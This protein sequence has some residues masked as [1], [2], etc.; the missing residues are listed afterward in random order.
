MFE[1][2]AEEYIVRKFGKLTEIQRISIPII[3]QRKNCLIM[4]PTGSGKTLG[5]LVPA[6][7]SS[8]S[9]NSGIKVIY[10]T[11]LKAL[12]RDIGLRM[13]LFQELGVRYGIRHG[14]SSREERKKQVRELPDVIITTP[15]TFQ[16]MLIRKDFMLK[17]ID[18]VIIDELHELLESKRGVQLSL[19]LERLEKCHGANFCRVGL[20]ATISEPE[21]A[22][23]FLCGRNREGFI[24]SLE[25]EREYEI[26]VK[27]PMPIKDIANE[28]VKESETEKVLVFT[29]TRESAEVFANLMKNKCEVHHGSLSKNVREHAEK[30]FREGKTKILIATSSLE[31]GIDIGDI[32]RVI[33]IGSPK[34]VEKLL[35]RIGRSNHHCGSRAVGTIYSLSREDY[36]EALA[37]VEGMKK[38]YMQSLLKNSYDVIAQQALGIVIEMGECDVWFV[39][40]VLSGST[41]YEIEIK[42]LAQILFEMSRNNLLIYEPR[43]GK[44]FARR[45]GVIHYLSTLSFI[46]STEKFTMMDAITNKKIAYLDS[47]F[48]AKLEQEDVFIVKGHAWKAV[49]I[50]DEKKIVRAIPEQSAIAIPEWLGEEIP[51][52]E[53][54]AKRVAEMLNEK[55]F[56]IE[57]IKH[58]DVFVIYTHLGLKKNKALELLLRH[59]FSQEKYSTTT[60]SDGYRIVIRDQSGFLRKEKI[61]E[62]IKNLK[63]DRYEDAVQGS[64]HYMNTLLEVLKHFGAVEPSTGYITRDYAKLWKDT[65]YAEEALCYCAEKYFDKNCI[66]DITKETLFQERE[67]SERSKEFFRTYGIID[68]EGG[69][70]LENLRDNIL[71]KSVEL[72]CCYCHA[73]IT[74][75]V[76]SV[77]ERPRCHRCGSPLLMVWDIKGSET[78]VHAYG[79]RAV[80]ALAVYGINLATAKRVLKNIRSEEKHFL[81]DLLQ[82]QLNF[83][84]T[85]KYWEV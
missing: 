39:H 38:H 5:A 9:A 74:K 25:K 79:R 65:I 84:R 62:K 64:R 30:R 22:L 82:A 75:R 21:T 55:Q 51:L 58:S 35:Q 33:Q 2:E 31:L 11:P 15:E 29:N 20:S 46:P 3:L 49:S 44:L 78:L 72:S 57:E 63:I 52:D 69:D 28:V 13:E 8:R 61:L 42:K 48:V 10:I 6:I 60:I 45:R 7:L 4:A 23:R 66:E 70:A 16:S 43:S 19:S 41:C 47:N 81:W 40:S 77:E 73:K 59:D 37:L 83:I 27:K 34:R 68:V 76:E 14:D 18:F 12:N 32:K 50:E 80:M 54:T 17:S 24:A 36:Y 26:Q 67:L 85:R 71:S 53:A 1:R 56:I